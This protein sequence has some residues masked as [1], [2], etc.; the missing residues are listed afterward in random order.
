MPFKEH[1][2]DK[3]TLK[4]RNELHDLKLKSQDDL[5]NEVVK[6]K[7]EIK[8]LHEQLVMLLEVSTNY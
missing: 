7:A 3:L 1:I 4:E 5:V 2:E 6:S 8:H